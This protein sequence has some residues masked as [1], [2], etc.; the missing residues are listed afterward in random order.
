MVHN[1]EGKTLDSVVH[2]QILSVT[3]LCNSLFFVARFAHDAVCLFT[4]RSRLALSWTIMIWFQIAVILCT[5]GIILQ[6]DS[7]QRCTPN[8]KRRVQCPIA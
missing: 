4:R 8:L 2:T 7:P 6:L 1:T 5:R 3:T